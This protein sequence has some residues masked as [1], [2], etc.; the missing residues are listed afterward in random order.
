M[1]SLIFCRFS[2]QN[3]A[4]MHG[5]SNSRLTRTLCPDSLVLLGTA[6]RDL[7]RTLLE[8]CLTRFRRFQMLRNRL[9]HMLLNLENLPLLM[10]Y[11]RTICNYTSVLSI[12]LPSYYAIHT[13]CHFNSSRQRRVLEQSHA[14]GFEDRRSSKILLS[15]P[16]S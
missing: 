6:K 10:H 5:T 11:V 8:R 9:P 7:T 15:S 13:F 14:G 4:I 1:K 2:W 3:I 12:I 16:F